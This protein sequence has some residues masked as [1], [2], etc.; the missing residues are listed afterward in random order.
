MTGN[1]AKKEQLLLFFFYLRI[2]KISLFKIIR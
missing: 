2:N 1:K